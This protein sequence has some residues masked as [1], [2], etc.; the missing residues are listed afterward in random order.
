MKKVYNKPMVIV[1]EFS[2]QDVLCACAIQNTN[3]S[4]KDQCGMF[5]PNTYGY[6]IFAQG[7]AACIMDGTMYGYCYQ[8][9]ASNNNVFSS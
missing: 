6:M 5:A 8:P 4:E 7:W 1:E 2:A 9:G 3:L